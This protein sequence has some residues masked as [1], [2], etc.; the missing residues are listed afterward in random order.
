MK[1]MVIAGLALAACAS[2]AAAKSHTAADTN[3]V[4]ISGATTCPAGT[5]QVAAGSHVIYRNPNNGNLTEDA[6]CWATVPA[7]TAQIEV[8]VLGPCVVCRFGP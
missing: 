2:V 8:N 1:R 4:G 6:R 3:L 5:T 7:S